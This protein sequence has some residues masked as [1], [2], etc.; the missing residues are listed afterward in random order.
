[1]VSARGVSVRGAGAAV[2][3]VLVLISACGSGRSVEAYCSVLEEHKTQYLERFD[4]ANEQ[5]ADETLEG[6]VSGLAGG[7]GAI[8]DLQQMWEELAEV[9]P[10]EIRADVETVRDNYADQ[11]DLAE[12]SATDPL[13]ALGSALM[14]GLL[15]SGSWS[16]VDEWTA[17]NCGP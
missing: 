4:E 6:F 3:A 11:L 17:E 1:M 9:A 8:G 10:E 7:M 2:A 15:S 16:R 5:L 14:G 12:E 13:A